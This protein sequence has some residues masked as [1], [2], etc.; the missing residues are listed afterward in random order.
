MT[1]IIT[2]LL[3]IALF[4]S[5]VMIIFVMIFYIP[6]R[7]ARLIIA[8]IKYFYAYLMLELTRKRFDKT[9]ERSVLREAEEIL[10]E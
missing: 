3:Y 9:N 2:A 8:G 10:N 7:V 6:I 1:A 4:I 5:V